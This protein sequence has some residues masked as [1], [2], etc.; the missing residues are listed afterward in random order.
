MTCTLKLKYTPAVIP[1]G[2]D[3]YYFLKTCVSLSCFFN[4]LLDYLWIQFS[5]SLGY[6]FKKSDI[7]LELSSGLQQQCTKYVLII[8]SISLIYDYIA[9]FIHNL[10][11]FCFI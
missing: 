8:L 11:H 10:M 7:L 6:F 1:S 3:E 9:I 2:S 4:T 5:A